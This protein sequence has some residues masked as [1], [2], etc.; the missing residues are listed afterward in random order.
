[1]ELHL[2]VLDSSFVVTRCGGYNG[3]SSWIEIGNYSH[4]FVTCTS[5]LCV[6]WN[7]TNG[8]LDLSSYSSHSYHL[9]FKNN[10]FLILIWL[11]FCHMCN[12]FPPFHLQI[13]LKDQL[14]NLKGCLFFCNLSLNSMA[15]CGL[16][17]NGFCDLD[18]F[19]DGGS[20]G[21]VTRNQVYINTSMTSEKLHMSLASILLFPSSI[22]A[23]AFIHLWNSLIKSLNIIL[24]QSTGSPL[25]AFIIK[26]AWIHINEIT[27]L[28]PLINCLNK[29]KKMNII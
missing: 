21:Y 9:L 1:M 26:I 10:N 25:F 2:H 19:G 29:C 3:S 4:S 17:T 14:D 27:N 5:F 28:I 22:L 18:V 24:A 16:T 8:D 23:K 7:Y 11:S 20:L 15:L 13:Y 12:F 6:G